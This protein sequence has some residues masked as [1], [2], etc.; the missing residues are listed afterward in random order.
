MKQPPVHYTVV[1]VDPSLA[2]MGVWVIPTTP[3]NL[4]GG[5]TLKT[6]PDTH[7][8][9]RLVD[10]Q[11]RLQK[12]LEKIRPD[13]VVLE[14]YVY[15]SPRGGADSRSF[16]IGGVVRVLLWHLKQRTLLVNP[17]QLK[18]FVLG[19]GSGK[20]ELIL[21]QVYKRWDLELSDHNQADAYVLAR[22]GEAYC[23]ADRLGWLPVYEKNTW[24]QTKTDLDV[25][26]TLLKRG[27]L[28]R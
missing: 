9:E 12:I 1:G 13:L 27:Y 2:A 10:L 21:Q 4:A 14:D 26:T 28:L 11:Q 22:I 20:K 6:S 25:V 23:E 24:I 18:K 16:E 3:H 17:G 8:V 15:S 7:P 19:K 5:Y